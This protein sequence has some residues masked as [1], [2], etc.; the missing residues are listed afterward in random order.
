MSWLL[1]AL[2]TI[3]LWAAWAFLA[4]ISLRTIEPI[5]ATLL[6]GL[7]SLLVAG[8]GLAAGQKASSWISSGVWVGGAAAVCGAAGILTFSF[9]LD[10][11]KVSLVAPLVG[12]YP[13][14]V[15][16]L[17]VAF[18][19]ERLTLAQT[20]GVLLALIGVGLVGAGG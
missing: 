12:I 6:F 19:S 2:L 15:V 17:S 16:L 5:Q 3:T 7:A 11:G 13:A 10:R 14:L 20:A 9:A 18:L 1:Y 4:K 8:A